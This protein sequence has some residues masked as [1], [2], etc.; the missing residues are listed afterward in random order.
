MGLGSVQAVTLAEVRV[1]AK[2]CR[3]LIS[4]GKNPLELRITTRLAS[5]LEH[6][7]QTNFDQ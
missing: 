6:T 3:S 4:D 2:N 5:H 7:K 1:K